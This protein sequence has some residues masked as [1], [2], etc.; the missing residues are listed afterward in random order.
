[1]SQSEKLCSESRN[2]GALIHDV[3]L[4]AWN[5]AFG[6]MG[7]TYLSGPITTGPRF[8]DEALT[9]AGDARER[10]FQANCAELQAT[11]ARLRRER[12]EIVVEPASLSIANWGQRDY[13]SL[14]EAFIERH[15]RLVIFM[16]GWQFSAGCAAEFAK[17]VESGIRAETLEGEVLKTGQGVAMLRAAAD[18]MEDRAEFES[19]ARLRASIVASI[20]RIDAA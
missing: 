6:D 17:A 20:S 18:S 15:V 11:A 14:W 3:I 7:V 13:I 4:Q 19:V 9:Q 2:G 10:A 1:M 8:L 5:C 16:P 12:R